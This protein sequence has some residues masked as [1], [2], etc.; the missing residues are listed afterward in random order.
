[1]LSRV[2]IGLTL[3]P[4]FAGMVETDQ[5]VSH[6]LANQDRAKINAF[7]D[8]KDVVTQLQQQG[9][10]A[11]DSARPRIEVGYRGRSAQQ[12]RPLLEGRTCPVVF[13]RL[14][15]QGKF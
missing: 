9:V 2:T 13:H 12:A 11:A 4:A 7:L 15:L 3:Q 6:E 5:A 1:M 10:S 14:D 8:R